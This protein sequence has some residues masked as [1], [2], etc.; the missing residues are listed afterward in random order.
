VSQNIAL[1]MQ[2]YIFP[3]EKCSLV[4]KQTLKQ[5]FNSTLYEFI[6]RNID[7]KVIEKLYRTNVITE[8]LNSD[9]FEQ[10]TNLLRD[11]VIYLG[12]T[13]YAKAYMY[14]HRLAYK[15]VASALGSSRRRDSVEILA[16]GIQGTL[17]EIAVQQFLET[18][19][20]VKTELDFSID[21]KTEKYVPTD[22]TNI[23]EGTNKRPLAKN[24]SIKS[25]K[26][27]GIWLDIHGRQKEKSDFFIF[28]LVGNGFDMLRK[29]Q[30]T[31]EKDALVKLATQEGLLDYFD[32]K[33]YITRDKFPPVPVIIAGIAPDENEVIK[34]KIIIKDRRNRKGELRF[35]EVVSF[36]GWLDRGKTKCKPRDL[37][38][39][40]RFYGTE[41]FTNIDHYIVS[42]DRLKNDRV[43][44]EHLVNSIAFQEIKEKEVA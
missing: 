13:D 5:R 21:K 12:Y 15:L 3:Q 36:Q 4:K 31:L 42:F 40:V 32:E 6:P 26:F 20:G 39:D 2:G 38:G 34:K 27:G 35:K 44:W 23:I 8:N 30:S 33:L 14:Q 7:Q 11:R 22:L 37:S 29:F 24:V 43:S 1:V 17:G 9:N 10:V 16:N 28:T 41:T 19:F 18:R 25:T